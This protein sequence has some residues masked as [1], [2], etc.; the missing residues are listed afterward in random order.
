MKRHFILMVAIS[1]MLSVGAAF[2]GGDACDAQ[3][4]KKIFAKCAACHTVKKGGATLLGPNLH[5]VIDRVSGTL[6]G[7]PYSPALMAYQKKWTEKELDHFLQNPMK[8]VPGTMMVFRG[9]Q[10]ERDR[11]EVLCYL[12]NNS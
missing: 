9:L 2:A 6:E 11:R 12:R 3:T 5:G 8:V 10:K 4:S 1:S 7:Y